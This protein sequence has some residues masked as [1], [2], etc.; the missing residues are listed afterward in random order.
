MTTTDQA[1]AAAVR[2]ATSAA[3]RN[4]GTRG[5]P[6]PADATGAQAAARRAWYAEYLRRRPAPGGL[7]YS[8]DVDYLAYGDPG[9]Q[10]AAAPAEPDTGDQPD[11]LIAGVIGGATA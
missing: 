1:T 8:S 11:D 2:H 5:C 10:A 6:Y 9:D 3:I 4:T 7:D